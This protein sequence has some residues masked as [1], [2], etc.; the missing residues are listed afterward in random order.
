MLSFWY[1]VVEYIHKWVGVLKNKDKML[2][3]LLL[4]MKRGTNHV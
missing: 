4:E 1:M 3:Q 2:A